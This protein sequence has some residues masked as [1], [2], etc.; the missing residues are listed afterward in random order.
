M[1]RNYSSK[2]SINVKSLAIVRT[3]NERILSSNG[4]P[5]IMNINSIDKIIS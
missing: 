1:L 5:K 3:Q 2:K 4:S